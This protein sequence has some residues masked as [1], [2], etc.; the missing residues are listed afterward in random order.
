MDGWNTGFPLGWYIFRGYVSFMEA[1]GVIS[2]HIRSLITPYTYIVLFVGPIFPVWFKVAGSCPRKTC[3]ETK[4]QMVPTDLNIGFQPGLGGLMKRAEASKNPVE[5]FLWTR[6]PVDPWKGY[7][8]NKPLRDP[9]PLIVFQSVKNGSL[10][11]AGL[12]CLNRSC[13]RVL[14]GGVFKGRG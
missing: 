5:I 9:K 7:K 12:P 2:P 4:P 10:A 6:G 3:S 13:Y 11:V 8:K 1:T 14:K